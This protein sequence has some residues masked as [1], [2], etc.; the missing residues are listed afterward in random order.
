MASQNKLYTKGPQSS[1]RLRMTTKPFSSSAQV[2]FNYHNH[3]MAE[4][5]HTVTMT[6]MIATSDPCSTQRPSPDWWDGQA[7]RPARAP[8]TSPEKKGN[9]ELCWYP[10]R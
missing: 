7:G 6:M 5:Q 4:S 8:E 2:V 1:E 3:A 9:V 10:C